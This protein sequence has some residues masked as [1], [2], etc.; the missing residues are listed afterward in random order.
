MLTGEMQ[1]LLDI[2]GS[3]DNSA[4]KQALVALWNTEGFLIDNPPIE[5]FGGTFDKIWKLQNAD[6][7]YLLESFLR[8][9]SEIILIS[10]C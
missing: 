9:G 8:Y 7:L 6:A 3:S 2:N 10:I 4:Y 5:R 1:I